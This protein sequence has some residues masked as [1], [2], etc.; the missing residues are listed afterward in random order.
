MEAVLERGESMHVDI[1][2][3]PTLEEALESIEKRKQREQLPYQVQLES[4][5]GSSLGWVRAQVGEKD[6][7]DMVQ[8]DWLIVGETVFFASETPS[9]EQVKTAVQEL[10]ER[11]Q[12]S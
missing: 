8:K 11:K 1:E 3:G 12:H 7:L 2:P 4:E 6:A 10:S 9:Y 5:L